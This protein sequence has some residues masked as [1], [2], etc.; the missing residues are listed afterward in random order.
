M[1]IDDLHNAY[2]P[3]EFDQMYGQTAVVKTLNG[4]EKSKEWPHSFL[5]VGQ[6]GSGKCV[7][8]D[9]RILTQH[10]Q[11]RIDSFSKGIEGFTDFKL[12]LLG[13]EG[14]VTSSHFFEEEAQK[15][16]KVT[17]SLGIEITGTPEHKLLTLTPDLEFIYKRLDDLAIG[18]ALCVERDQSIFPSTNYEIQFEFDYLNCNRI[19]KE[20]C[21]AFSKNVPSHLN[22]DLSR[23]L[24]YVI[25]NGTLSR[26]SSQAS[27]PMS[28]MNQRIRKDIDD[29]LIKYGEPSCKWVND[30]DGVLPLAFSKL[31]R[32]LVGPENETTARYKKVPDC[33]LESSK[34]CQLAFLQA[35]FDCDSSLSDDVLEYSTSSR[36]LCIDVQFMLLNLGIVSKRVSSY[37]CEFDHTYYALTVLRKDI[38]KFFSLIDSLKYENW[39]LTEGNTNLDGAPFANVVRDKILVLK[40]SILNVSKNGT[41]WYNGQR[42][43]WDPVITSITSDYA[44]NSLI[45]KSR[46]KKLIAHLE[47]QPFV[48]HPYCE[49]FI[50]KLKNLEKNFYF[51]SKVH[52]IVDV[53]ERQKVYDFTIPVTHNFIANG[54]VN[55]NTT[56]AR[57]I[58]SK[59]GC[60]ANQIIEID[61]ATYNNVDSVRSLTAGTRYKGFGET[62]SK[63]YL[64]DEVHR[65]SKQSWDALL[66]TLE[67]PPEHVYFILCTTE[68]GKVPQT[69]KSRCVTLIFNALKKSELEDLVEDVA[70]A[71]NI[72]LPKGA[73][74]LIAGAAEGSPRQALTTLAKCR[75][76]SDL[77]E[78]QELVRQCGETSEVI[79]LCR[80]LANPKGGV[81]EATKLIKNLEQVEAEAVRIQICRYFE[82]IFLSA[83]GE[84]SALYALS[85]LESFKNPYRQTD[86]LAPLILS[87]GEVLFQGGDE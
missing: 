83:K 87:V 24:G 65:F 10:G 49:E 79:D 59:V 23:M 54:I 1:A 4:F 55:H 12:K 43:Y 18:D 67:E 13:K 72:K 37:N 40:K 84:D 15:L 20:K 7:T 31:L 25:A 34:E 63:V 11:K 66:K 9:T 74:S 80:F 41:Y 19:P 16:Y 48:N 64:I 50:N 70:E 62:P 78:V 53:H 58:A 69:I 42:Y 29:I 27:I 82:K 47:V 75:S 17:D 14:E 57:I 22:T 73:V 21:E 71:E 33:V 3:Q 2:R 35:L 38:P 81:A 30:I 61:A 51:F 60:P 56:S 8:G 86:G 45:T 44:S 6:A 85:V 39:P 36:E 26:K 52:S 28:T 5:M 32:Q 76:V 46:L 77:K 68:E